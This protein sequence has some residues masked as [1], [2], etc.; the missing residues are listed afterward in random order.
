MSR[1]VTIIGRRL[2][3]DRFSFAGNSADCPED[4]FEGTNTVC[5]AAAG[6]CDR[7]ETCSGKCQISRMFLEWCISYYH[8]TGDSA[9][10]PPNAFLGSNTVCRPSIGACD[11]AERCTGNSS[12]CPQDAVETQGTQCRA[13]NTSKEA[14]TLI[15]T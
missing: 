14:I 5:R 10:C 8:L 4:E 15:T 1:F 6:D 12:S 13:S 3:A 11:V 9:Q 7:P 2:G